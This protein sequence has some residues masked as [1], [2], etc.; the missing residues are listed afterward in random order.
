MALKQK[1]PITPGQRFRIADDYDDLTKRVPEKS[2]LERLPKKAGRDWRGR[3]SMR[4]RGGGNKI[5]Y[6]MID[7]KRNKDM[8]AKVVGIEYDPN[9]NA[10]I[11]LLQYEDGEKRYIIAPIGVK[12]GDALNSGAEAEIRPGNALPLKSIPLGTIV[13]NIELEPGVGG[14]MARAAGAGVTL[15]A[16]EKGY[17]ILKMPSGEQRMVLLTCRATIG[18]VGNVE[19]KNIRKGKAGKSR[20]IGRRPHVRGVVMNPCDHPHGGGEGKSGI[21]LKSPVTPWGKPTLGKKTR[22]P[23]RH[24]DRLILGRRKR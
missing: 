3:I 16:K 23:K 19:S 4:H 17:A 5:M 9:R 10:R 6:R 21:G 2:L 1:R 12:D 7:F 24:S 18:Q 8:P 11:A 15:L 20:H 13:H 22:K 14:K